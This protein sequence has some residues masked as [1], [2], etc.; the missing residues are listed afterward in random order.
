MDE[1][2]R[3]R[4]KGVHASAIWDGDGGSFER[5]GEED[6]HGQE[7]GEDSRNNCTSVGETGLVEPWGPRQGR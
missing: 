6:E 2:A 5:I 1:H 3:M 7:E 4:E